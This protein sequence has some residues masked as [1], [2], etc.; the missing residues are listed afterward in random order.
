MNK[1]LTDLITQADQIKNETEKGANTANRIGTM[2]NDMITSSQLINTADNPPFSNFD[3]QTPGVYRINSACDAI[4]LPDPSVMTG[5]CLV[6]LNTS[7]NVVLFGSIKP[8][9][10][11]N[12][13]MGGMGGLS[14]IT[15][16]AVGTNWIYTLYTEI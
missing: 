1:T 11:E 10:L 13:E 14:T 3:I 5:A 7:G 15:M 4:L 9:N 2:L 12:T 6:I 16:Y 8:I